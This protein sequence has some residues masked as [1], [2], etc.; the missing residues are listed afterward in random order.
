MDSIVM[1]GNRPLMGQVEIQGSK[2]A[3]LPLIAAATLVHGT[4][5]LTGCPC[6]SDRD[7]ML[8][9]FEAVGGVVRLQEKRQGPERIEMDASHIS[10]QNI[11]AEIA[12]KLRS[13]ILYVGA[14]L[15]R[16]G[17]ACVYPPGGCVIGERPIDQH[18]M[19]LQEAGYHLTEK[20]DF[21]YLE[22]GLEEISEKR[23]ILQFPS[24]G[25]TEN[26]LLA[27]VLGKGVVCLENVSREPEIEVLCRFLL[28]AGADIRGIGTTSLTIRQVEELHDVSYTVPTD[29]IAAA[30]YALA[31]MATGGIVELVRAPVPHMHAVLT[32]LEQMGGTVLSESDRITIIAPKVLRPVP[33]VETAV[34]PGFP[35]DLQSLLLV[36]LTEAAGAS[37]I[38]ETIFENR[39]QVV[40]EVRKMGAHIEID[41]NTAMIAGFDR[42]SG[43]QVE[44]RELRGGAA[45]VIAGLMADGRT[46]LKNTGYID[47]GYEDIVRDCRL[48]GAQIIRKGSGTDT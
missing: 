20:E 45:L 48:L 42:L 38:R 44:V 35:T 10:G 36:T 7:D 41:Q 11:P 47:R 24:V 21:L 1:Y 22:R 19:K 30:T 46:E 28:E 27:T 12:G 4:V 37:H 3:A 9:L 32:L 23:I 5:R 17:N 8:R 31:A 29:R 14:M 6:I 40:S 16:T 2:N 26:L 18:L 34:Y 25:V 33:Y 39:F 15:G 43:A 13:S